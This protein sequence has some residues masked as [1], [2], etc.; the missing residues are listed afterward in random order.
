[1]RS[2]IKTVALCR[3]A[4]SKGRFTDSMPCPCR[5]GKGLDCVFP[6]WCTQCGRVWFTL[7]MPC[8][9]HAVLLKATA[10]HVRRET[11]SGLLASGRLLP[12]T[13]KVVIRSIPI[14]DAGGQCET[15]QRLSWTRKSVI[16]A[17]YKKK[18]CEIVGLGDRIFPVTTRTFTKDTALSE[19]GRGTV[20]ARHGHGMLC[21]NR[22]LMGQLVTR[23]GLQP[24]SWCLSALINGTGI[25]KCCL[26]PITG[27]FVNISA[28]ICFTVVIVTLSLEIVCGFDLHVERTLLI[29]VFVV[30]WRCVDIS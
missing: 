28:V 6:I 30:M 22:P 18:I 4:T 13:T 12:A 3:N 23:T 17:H 7:A 26:L 8:S 5:A 14:S 11:A 29:F 25:F 9:D 21:V 1:M 16:A 27:P 15:K 19:H 2:A 10:Q 24:D 20:W